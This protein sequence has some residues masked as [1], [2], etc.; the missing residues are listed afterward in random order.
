MTYD[1]HIIL[2][3]EI[4]VKLLEGAL[5][6]ADVPAVWNEEFERMFGIKV[7]NDAQGCLQDIHWSLGTIGY[8]PTYTLGNLNAAQLFHRAC[9]DHPG[10]NAELREGRYGTLLSWLRTRIHQ[11]GQRHRPLELMQLAT[12]EPTRAA[13][14]VENL[15]NKFAS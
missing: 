3:F 6:V 13:W 7:P 11:H 9:T 1:L 10:L 2:R 12:G 15:R 14:H 4:E 8:F 5:K